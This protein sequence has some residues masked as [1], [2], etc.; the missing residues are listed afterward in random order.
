MLGDSS[1]SPP[2]TTR[3]PASRSAGGVSLSRNPLA[4]ALS[5]PNTYSSRSKVVSISTLVPPSAAR[6]CA[7]A[8]RPS[9]TG[10]RTSIRITSGEVGGGQRD[11]LRA[12]R[13]GA[14]HGSDR[15]RCRSST[16]KPARTSAWSSTISTVIM[17]PPSAATSAYGSV[18]VEVE[19][20]A[21]PRAAV[22][23]PPKTATRSRI[24]IS[25]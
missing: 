18:A 3:I 8:C 7:V 6:I 12:V 25:P 9:I 16:S 5:A 20:A 19:A 15:R 2:A 24:P 10:I 22:S 21:G 23:V 13:R 1:A 14:D 17:P 4:P 11:G